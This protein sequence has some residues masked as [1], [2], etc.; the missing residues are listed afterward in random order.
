MGPPLVYNTQKIVN[1]TVKAHNMIAFQLHQQEGRPAHPRDSGGGRRDG[2]AGARRRV[3]DEAV[4][5]GVLLQES[6]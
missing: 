5:G 6:R 1:P 3:P 2:A 4:G